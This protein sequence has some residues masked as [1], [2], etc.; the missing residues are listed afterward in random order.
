MKL[1]NTN[2]PQLDSSNCTTSS[3]AWLNGIGNTFFFS[4]VLEESMTN[5]WTSKYKDGGFEGKASKSQAAKYQVDEG[6][7]AYKEIQFTVFPQLDG[8]CGE[9]HQHPQHSVSFMS[10]TMVEYLAPP[11]QQE[12]VHS[13]CFGAYPTRMVLPLEMTE[14]PVYV[15]AKQYHGILRRRQS[16]AKA[17][18]EKK[19]IKV[20]KPYLHESRHLHAMRRVRGCGGRFINTKKLENGAANTTSDMVNS[21]SETVP[22]PSTNSSSAHSSKNADPSAGN[23]AIE[24]PQLTY[25]SGNGNGC[26]QSFLGFQLSSYHSQS[27]SMVEERD[28]NMKELW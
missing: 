8:K 21:F 27:D 14:E 22:K 20:R 26:Y 2:H 10:P 15:N 24:S 17:E 6:L 7:D 1:D 23:A 25:T 9:E 13:H 4:D 28:C 3:K 12:H 5:L 11:T 18:L 16:R 19:L